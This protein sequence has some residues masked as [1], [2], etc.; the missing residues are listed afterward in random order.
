MKNRPPGTLGSPTPPLHQPPTVHCPC[1][2][3]KRTQFAPHQVPRLYRDCRECHPLFQRNEPNY[4][5]SSPLLHF[6]PCHPQLRE[7]NPITAAG[8]PNPAKRTQFAPPPPS[9]QTKICETNPIPAAGEPHPAPLAEGP[10]RFI[11]KPNPSPAGPFVENQ[12][13]STP[14]ARPTTKNAKRT[15]FPPPPPDHDPN[16]QNE[17][18]FR[19]APQSANYQLPT[20]NQNMRNEPNPRNLKG[21][22]LSTNN[23][24]CRTLISA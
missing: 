24:C 7:T 19:P 12:P 10:P 21:G 13:N 9:P 20:T 11:R 23:F 18:N 6:C 22:S 16:A 15:Q 3:T 5:S 2:Y 14:H 1:N 17:P 4:F 8:K